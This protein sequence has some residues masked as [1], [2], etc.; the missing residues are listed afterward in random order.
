MA[1]H[2]THLGKNEIEYEIDESQKLFSETSKIK[3]SIKPD[4]NYL[5]TALCNIP[6]P[7]ETTVKIPNIP[8]SDIP[9]PMPPIEIP[10]TL[11]AALLPCAEKGLFPCPDIR[12]VDSHE[13][14]EEEFNACDPDTLVKIPYAMSLLLN[15][16]NPDHQLTSEKGFLYIQP[17]FLSKCCCDAENDEDVIEVKANFYVK[18]PRFNI[19]A[20]DMIKRIWWEDVEDNGCLQSKKLMV[21]YANLIVRNGRVQFGDVTRVEDLAYAPVSEF[22]CDQ[23]N[24]KDGEYTVIGSIE[25]NQDN[26]KTTISWRELNLRFCCGRL[27]SVTTGRSDSVT[28]NSG[29]TPEPEPDGEH[30]EN[31]NLM[32]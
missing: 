28:I 12:L 14:T 10:K 17:I 13:M 4:T 18:Y 30:Q 19:L 21:E 11:L 31:G 5:D 2:T 3:N 6:D 29:G 15:S 25:H 8:F 24:P 32:N 23:E 16:N 9:T 1:K 20:Q 27:V 26:D 22:G 7:P